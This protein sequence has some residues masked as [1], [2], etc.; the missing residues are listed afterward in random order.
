MRRPTHIVVIVLADTLKKNQR[1]KTMKIQKGIT[2]LT[3][4]G[5][6]VEYFL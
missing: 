4:I 2:A 3:Q 5:S 6:I 1:T